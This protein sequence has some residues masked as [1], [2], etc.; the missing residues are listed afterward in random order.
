MNFKEELK[1]VLGKVVSS[2]IKEKERNVPN[3]T[4]IGVSSQTKNITV[5][6]LFSV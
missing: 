6:K 1:D 5:V 2:T 3:T 4:I